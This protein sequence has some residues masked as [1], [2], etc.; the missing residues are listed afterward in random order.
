L[1][2]LASVDYVTIVSDETPLELIRLVRPDVLVKGSDNT[3]ETIVG[4]EDVEAYG[5]MVATV[6]YVDGVSTTHIIDSVC[7]S[8]L[9]PMRC[10]I[11]YA[12]CGLG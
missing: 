10:G 6:P 5:G 7:A 2:A 3:P 9:W 4:R 1:A 12:E 8:A 11:Q